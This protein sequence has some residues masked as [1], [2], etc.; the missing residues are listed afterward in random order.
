MPIS[1]YLKMHQ[2]HRKEPTGARC[3]HVGTGVRDTTHA[4]RVTLPSQCLTPLQPCER[5]LHGPYNP[6]QHIE[7]KI[8]LAGFM[9]LCVCA[10]AIQP[11]WGRMQNGAEPNST[12][13]T[14]PK[15]CRVTPCCI[16]LRPKLRPLSPGASF[17]ERC[18]ITHTLRT[19]K[20]SVYLIPLFLVIY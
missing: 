15:A 3:L 1:I 20:S 7:A 17:L 10:L 4:L 14:N 19:C 8:P 16:H 5:Q 6:V 13:P 12:R 18:V 9:S 2:R 11:A